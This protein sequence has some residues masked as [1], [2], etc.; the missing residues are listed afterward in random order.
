M[1][2]SMYL[3]EAA[4][5]LLSSAVSTLTYCAKSA[6]VSVRELVFGRSARHTATNSRSH[7]EQLARDDAASCDAFTSEGGRVDTR[8]GHE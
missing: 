6:A 8:P 1:N 3:I 4:H 5:S 7:K 2:K